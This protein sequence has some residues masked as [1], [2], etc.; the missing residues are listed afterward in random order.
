MSTE[1]RALAELPRLVEELRDS[2][3]RL[4]AVGRRLSDATS[5]GAG[6]G[7]VADVAHLVDEINRRLRI[8]DPDVFLAQLDGR[9]EELSE[10]VG[11]LMVSAA[12]VDEVLESSLRSGGERDVRARLDQLSSR[13]RVLTGA[14]V[15]GWLVL[16]VVL[17]AR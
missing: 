12:K 4:D 16:L 9:V 1:D 14:A 17:L 13:M 8:F 15:V 3:A 10:Q 11:R 5:S 6:P 7:D 2:L